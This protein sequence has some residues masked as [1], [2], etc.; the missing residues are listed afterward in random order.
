MP[1]GQALL[2]GSLRTLRLSGWSWLWPWQAL[3]PPVDGVRNGQVQKGQSVQKSL[4]C[5]FTPFL[6]SYVESVE[7][8]ESRDWEGLGR[9]P[10]CPLDMVRGGDRPRGMEQP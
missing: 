5:P 10:H 1:P 9:P 3:C 4:S 2:P 8:R 7:R 6:T